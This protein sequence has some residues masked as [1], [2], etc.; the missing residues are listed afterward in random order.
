[1][2]GIQLQRRLP[3]ALRLSPC[4]PSLPLFLCNQS[5]LFRFRCV[6]VCVSLRACPVCARAHPSAALRCPSVQPSAADT[7]SERL[8]TNDKRQNQD[9][10]RASQRTRTERTRG[11][12]RP[13]ET[14]AETSW[15]SGQSRAQRRRRKAIGGV[16]SGRR[17]GNGVPS[18]Q[19]RSAL[20]LLDSKFRSKRVR[21]D[22][23]H[24][25]LM[26]HDPGVA[27]HDRDSA[28]L[29]SSM[30]SSKQSIA[31]NGTDHDAYRYELDEK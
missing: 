18:L 17:K 29:S 2:I 3:R 19:I 10:A 15:T 14:A 31:F 23:R 12:R 26:G 5:F 9:Q 22:H 27:R 28:R 16:S 30:P 25:M 13:K 20:Q 7:G 6:A 21:T 1:M 8:T 11:T 4:S 24:C